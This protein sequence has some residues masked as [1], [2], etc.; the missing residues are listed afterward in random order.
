MPNYWVSKLEIAFVVG[1]SLWLLL[2]V[3]CGCCWLLVVADLGE[4]PIS[5][6]ADCPVFGTSQ[7]KRTN[8]NGFQ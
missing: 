6:G 8:K 3:G 7:K 2:V 5:L 1:C 4:L